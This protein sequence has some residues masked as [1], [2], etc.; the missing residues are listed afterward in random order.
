MKNS[1]ATPFDYET[2]RWGIAPLSSKYANFQ[3]LEM[4]FFIQDIARFGLKR[5]RVVDLGCG[6]GNI[7][8]FISR[9]FP[10]WRVTGIDIS[11]DALS[12][13]RTHYPK[14][15]FVKAGAHNI[16]GGDGTLDIV[17]A[18]DTM[19]HFDNL[20]EVVTKVKRKLR[21]GGI[22]YVAIPLEKQFPSLY[23]IMYK[24]GWR[25]KREF[26]GHVNFFNA[27]EFQSYI[28]RFGFKLVSKRYSNH[29][30]FS[31]VD[32]AYYLLQSLMGK[33]AVSF[34]S[35][36]SEMPRGVTR[37]ILNTFKN[38]IS[39]VTY[40]ESACMSFFPGG[41]GHFMFVKQGKHADFFSANPPF[42]LLEKLQLKYGMR[43]MIRPKDL[44]ISK[45]LATTGYSRAH[46]VLDYGC[47]TGIW[48]ERLI[49]GTRKRGIGVDVASG[50]IAAAKRT[51]GFRG[52]YIDTGHGWPIKNNSIDYC[53]S[54]DV[55]EHISDKENNLAKIYKSLDKGGKVLIYQLNRN[56][57]FTFDWLGDKLGSD[58]LYRRADHN[59]ALFSTP[60]EFKEMMVKTGFRNVTSELYDGPA[61]LVWDVWCY[62]YLACVHKLLTL[63]KL[64]HLSKYFL[65]VNDFVVR[66][67]FVV[68]SV[69]DKLV[70]TSGNS[71]GFFTWGEK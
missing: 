48:L 38:T 35:S 44:W 10:L 14:V 49:A 24:M 32:I 57:K 4:Q 21:E 15:N 71:N 60:D 22:L 29:V 69:V 59:R 65:I 17:Y 52:V 39:T 8:D 5:A 63:V 33:R 64:D 31:L 56:H 3:G 61:N 70:F 19:E 16:P 6:G 25:G 43:Y 47:G 42:S 26:A 36:V 58:Y 27:S 41:K 13:A 54:L 20:S 12:I 34:E 55:F 68:N 30:I 62:V 46:T 51:P 37:T 1:S 9:T 45:H 23:W 53:V 28:E 18:F 11:S 50:L 66:R 40:F 7:D 67:L 2:K